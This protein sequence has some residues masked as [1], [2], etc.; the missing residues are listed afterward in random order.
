MFTIF[1]MFG[2]GNLEYLQLLSH[3]TEKLCYL[4]PNNN[5]PRPTV[6][7]K[8]TT[9]ISVGKQRFPNVLDRARNEARRFG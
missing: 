5:I 6:D 3:K 8:N 9:L 1:A 4:F 2:F 7:E